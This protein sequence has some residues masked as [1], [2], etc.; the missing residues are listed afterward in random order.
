M[1]IWF[2]PTRPARGV[3][4]LRIS[5]IVIPEFQPTRPARGVTASQLRLIN[6]NLVSTHTPRTGRD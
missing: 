3:T 2:Q 6:A 4:G 5:L 1:G